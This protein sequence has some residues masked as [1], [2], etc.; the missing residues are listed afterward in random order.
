[1]AD[2]ALKKGGST[3]FLHM[4]GLVLGFTSIIF[5]AGASF[6]DQ[7]LVGFAL[8]RMSPTHLGLVLIAAPMA[9]GVAIL[10]GYAFAIV[11]RPDT[12]SGARNSPAGAVQGHSRHTGTNPGSH[13]DSPV[14]FA[15]PSDPLPGSE[16]VRRRF[17]V[18]L[19]L[20]TVLVYLGL[21]ALVAVASPLWPPG[22]TT[23]F[24]QLLL[25]VLTWFLAILSGPVA[26]QRT[27]KGGGGNFTRRL[28]VFYWLLSVTF[29]VLL[30][31]LALP[32][33]GPPTELGFYEAAQ[34][35]GIAHLAFAAAFL[36]II[37]PWGHQ[38]EAVKGLLYPWDSQARHLEEQLLKNLEQLEGCTP[39]CQ[40]M[41][42]TIR[43]ALIDRLKVLLAAV[44]WCRTKPCDDATKKAVLEERQK[45]CS[46]LK[47]EHERAGLGKENEPDC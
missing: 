1:M 37:D 13:A 20:L 15:D 5:V 12:D 35:A 36:V 41:Q 14:N 46:K 34:A 6:L 47:D 39:L 29:F 43:T 40:A 23:G 18:V 25:F 4:L 8:P 2:D 31:S 7:L 42:P 11:I 26:F 32:L 22:Q 16:E 19:V 9:S 27:V 17:S 33:V 3:S 24:W 44:R 10:L 30:Y 21:L 38:L 28:T 45:I